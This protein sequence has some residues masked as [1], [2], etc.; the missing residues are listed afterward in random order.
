ML[1]RDRIPV[2][3]L[4]PTALR[5]STLSSLRGKR[6]GGMDCLPFTHPDGAASLRYCVDTSFKN[7]VIS[8]RLATT[9]N[10]VIIIVVEAFF[11]LLF[12]C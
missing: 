1:G 4:T 7:Y 12:L 3:L 9:N 10:K 5:W 2:F 8:F 11:L 6:V